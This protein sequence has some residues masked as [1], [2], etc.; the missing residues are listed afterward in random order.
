[1]MH[2]CCSRF[3]AE[4]VSTPAGGLTCTTTL[5]EG[6]GAWRPELCESLPE[7]LQNTGAPAA[8]WQQPH[9]VMARGKCISQRPLAY[10]QSGQGSETK[11]ELPQPASLHCNGRPVHS[12]QSPPSPLQAIEK[13]QRLK[14][15]T[16][17][18][19]PAQQT[20]YTSA[21]LAHS[22]LPHAHLNQAC[23]PAEH[24]HMHPHISRITCKELDCQ[25]A[26]TCSAAAAASS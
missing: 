17:L 5:R 1:M 22:C 3:D 21:D 19:E 7:S 26:C 25:A 10:Q 15:S 12:W 13:R 8:A 4:D 9:V 20:R 23:S 16:L 18:A 14:F 24:W 2:A 6:V 11:Q